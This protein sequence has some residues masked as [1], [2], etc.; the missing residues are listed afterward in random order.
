MRFATKPVKM[1]C[2]RD[3]LHFASSQLNICYLKGKS[4]VR[5]TSVQDWL[6]IAY[7]SDTTIAN[8]TAKKLLGFR[9]L[10]FDHPFQVLNYYT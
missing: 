2:H 10:Y 8:K 4:M 6:N 5:R 7:L 1:V 9:P 3:G